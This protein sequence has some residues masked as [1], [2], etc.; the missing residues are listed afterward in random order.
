M[1][2][3]YIKN[4]YSSTSNVSPCSFILMGAIVMMINSVDVLNLSGLLLMCVEGSSLENVETSFEARGI[5]NGDG[6][7]HWITDRTCPDPEVR[8]YLY[9]RSNVDERQLIHI[10]DSWEASNLS[11]SLFDPRH[12]SKIIIHGFRADMFL[13]PLFEMKNGEDFSHFSQSMSLMKLEL[14]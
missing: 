9:T 12:A 3:Q 11:S 14:T 4:T 1:S 8:F 6:M 13:T 10:D 2:T 5:D 7:C